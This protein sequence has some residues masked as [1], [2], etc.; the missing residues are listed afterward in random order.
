MRV[1]KKLVP[2]EMVEKEHLE[3]GKDEDEEHEE[4][5]DLLGVLDVDILL[6]YGIFLGIL[7]ETVVKDCVFVVGVTFMLHSG[8]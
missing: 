5:N 4:E 2:R 7:M 1:H 6:W 3:E 8:W